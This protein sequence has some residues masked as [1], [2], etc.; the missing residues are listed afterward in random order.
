MRYKT[1]TEI[2]FSLVSMFT[3]GTETKLILQEFY[4]FRLTFTWPKESFWSRKILEFN[5]TQLATKTNKQKYLLLESTEYL[6]NKSKEI[7]K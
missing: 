7:C 6:K 4:K 2:F 1:S 5:I 3:C